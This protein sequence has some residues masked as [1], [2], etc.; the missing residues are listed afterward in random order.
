MTEIS[1][2]GD[3]Q[4]GSQAGASPQSEQPDGQ[5]QAA[6]KGTNSRGGHEDRIVKQ[7][8]AKARM[9]VFTKPLDSSEYYFVCVLVSY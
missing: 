7:T 5:P 4:S 9:N 8:R 6:V 2:Q 1:N 3:A